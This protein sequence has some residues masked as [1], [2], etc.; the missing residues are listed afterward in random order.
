M[1]TVI[2][3]F[4]DDATSTF[5]YVAFDR[6][7][8][9]AAIVDPVLDYDEATHATTTTSARRVLDFVREHSLLVDWILETHAH[10]DHLSAGA[11]L[12]EATGAPLA[13]GRGITQVQTHFGDEFDLD[14]RAGR[15]F[16]RLFDDGDE[17]SVGTLPARVIAT[18]GHT[19]DSVTYL[20]G[21]TAFIGDTLFAPDTGSARCDFPGGDARALHAS[22]AKLLALPPGT[23]LLLCHDY[24]KDRAPR[25]QW[26]IEEQRANVHL[27]GGLE[28]YVALRNARDATLPPPR[29]IGP[30]LRWN[31]RGRG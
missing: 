25:A 14:D 3:S 10:A 19:P 28:A 15:R 16:D 26:S 1:Q 9:H 18:P 4:H 6:D 12:R 29:L 30:A 27:Q 22:I 8:G 20:I 5:T 23:R 11:F 2:C 7:G 17:F 21:D 24:P 13:I 31:L